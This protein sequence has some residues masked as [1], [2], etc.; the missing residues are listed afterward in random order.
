MKITGN[1]SGAVKRISSSNIR[2]SLKVFGA[3]A[4]TMER[5]E[6]AQVALGKNQRTMDTGVPRERRNTY[7]ETYREKSYA[8]LARLV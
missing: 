6:F 5:R 8:G 2:K 3:R 4:D 7:N 1:S